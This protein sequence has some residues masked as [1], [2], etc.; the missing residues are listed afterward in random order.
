MY[1]KIDKFDNFYVNENGKIKNRK[2]GKT[3]KPYK[4]TG[5][6]YYI[7]VSDNGTIKRIAVHRAVALCFVDGHSSER[8]VVEH[9]DGNKENNH[10][11]NLLWVTQK[12]N[13]M[14]GY[15]RRQDNAIR[16]YCKCAMYVNGVYVQTFK[17]IDAAC[18]HAKEFYNAKYYQL[19]KHRKYKDIELRKV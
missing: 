2:T 7:K 19:N 8:N 18:R 6:Y 1:K 9:K 16:N 5:G 12:E 14:L 3:I 4:G 15:A 13:L 11:T 10:Y 17:S